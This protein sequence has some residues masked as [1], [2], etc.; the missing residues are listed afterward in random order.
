MKI[1]IT[2]HGRSSGG[3]FTLVELL[4]VIAIGAILALLATMA[5]ARTKE[6]AKSISCA[7]NLRN[8]HGA[9][10][11]YATDNGDRLAH[12]LGGGL[13]TRSIGPRSDLNW[14]NN[15]LNWELDSDNTNLAFAANGPL[16]PFLNKGSVHRC[17][18]DVALS[19]TQRRAGWS[20]RVR[21]YSMNAMVGDAGENSL[22]GAN[23]FNPDYRQ[24]I[25]LADFARPA[26]IF[27]FIEEHPDS[28]N[29][30]YFLNRIEDSQWLDL[31]ASSHNGG[32][33]LTF[34]DGHV[35][36]HHWIEANT[37]KPPKPDCALLPLAVPNAQRLDFDWLMERTSDE[38][39]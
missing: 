20:N 34:A 2:N 27:V 19:D 31:P 28:I 7:N 35:E 33:W 1:P 36:N 30:G 18:S 5:A 11:M 37:R 22:L 9:W 12:N 39:P 26:G 6:K 13:S 14:V 4:T 21:S 16:A 29:D 32:A 8:L 23:I 17:P 10:L 15:I 24:F 25:R 3:A 38:V